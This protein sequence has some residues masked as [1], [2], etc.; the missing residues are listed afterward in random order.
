MPAPI[1]H[2]PTTTAASPS[3]LPLFSEWFASSGVC[4]VDALESRP[5]SSSSDGLHTSRMS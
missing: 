5:S 1:T 2:A 3:A 4:N